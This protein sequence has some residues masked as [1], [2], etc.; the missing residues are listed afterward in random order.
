MFGMVADNRL[1]EVQ[2]PIFAKPVRLLGSAKLLYMPV[3]YAFFVLDLKLVKWESTSESE[4]SPCLKSGRVTND[5]RN[6]TKCLNRRVHLMGG[7][8][9][10][11]RIC[12]VSYPAR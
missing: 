1:C 7:S 3:V 11:V 2:E 10:T 6:V 12:T 8:I 4:P 9:T 5:P